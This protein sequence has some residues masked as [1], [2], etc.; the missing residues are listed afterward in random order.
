MLNWDSDKCILYAY[1]NKI[2]IP[3]VH[4]ETRTDVYDSFNEYMHSGIYDDVRNFLIPRFNDIMENSGSISIDPGSIHIQQLGISNYFN[5]TSYMVKVSFTRPKFGPSRLTTIVRI[6]NVTKEGYVEIDGVKYSYSYML[7]QQPVISYEV[8]KD[9]L[10]KIRNGENYINVINNKKSMK[11]QFSDIRNSGSKN[12]SLTSYSIL[13]VLF[14]MAINEGYDTRSV[15]SEFTDFSIVNAYTDETT[16]DQ[17]LFGIPGNEK[18]FAAT[19]YS[20]KIVPKLTLTELTS[21]YNSRSYNNSSIRNQLN[22]ML[23]LDRVKDEV[24]ARDVY[25]VKNPGKKLASSGSVITQSM[26]TSFKSEY[27]YKVYIKKFNNMDGLFLDEDID[28]TFAPKGL[29]ITEEIAKFFPDEKG[30]Y[31]SRD[32]TGS[33]IMSFKAGTVLN[34][35]VMNVLASVGY[36]AI[37][38]RSSNSSSGNSKQLYLMEECISNRQFLDIDV[39]KG[40]DGKWY[41]LNANNE[42]V[43]NNGA[44][45]TYDIAALISIATKIFAGNYRNIIVNADTGFRKRVVNIGEQYHNAF[46]YAV[47]AGFTQIKN[48]LRGF[49]KSSSSNKF[50]EDPDKIENNFYPITKSFVEYLRDIVRCLDRIDGD[51]VVNPI[52]F[53]SAVTRVNIY[54][55]DSHSVADSQRTLSIGSYGKLDPFEVP[56][57]GKLGVVNRLCCSTKIDKNGDLRTKYYP[58]RYASGTAKVLLNRER[59]MTAEEEE[60]YKIADISSIEVNEDGTIR[61]D[62]NTLIQCRV[63]S[64]DSI[65][66]STFAYVPVHDVDYVNADAQQTI[67]WACSTIPFMASNDSPRVTFAVAQEKQAKG[68]CEAEEPDVMT[69]SWEQFSW[70]NNK[71]CVRARKSGV[72]DSLVVQHNNGDIMSMGVIYDDGTNDMFD[73]PQIIDGPN[74]VTKLNPERREGERFDAGDI[75]ISSN[76][77]SENGIMTLGRNALVGY[78]CD[79]WNYEDGVHMSE[80]F[81]DKLRSYRLN[82]EKIEFNENT[83][84]KCRLSYPLSSGYLTPK[85]AKATVTYMRDR[86]RLTQ[87]VQCNNIY[88][89]YNDCSPIKSKIGRHSIYGIELSSLSVDRLE[90]GD[91]ISNR[92]GNKGVT[93]RISRTSEMPRLMNGKAL[94][95]CF[96]PLGVGS[97]MNI[98]QIK[99]LHTGLAAH[100]CK[101]RVST[102]AYNAISDEDINDLLSL[103]VDLMDSTGDASSVFSN[104]GRLFSEMD[105]ADE[106]KKY[107]LSNIDSIREYAGCFDKNGTTRLILPDN[108]GKLTETRIAVG[109]IYV[110]KLTQEVHKKIAAR[111]G[112]NDHES[113]SSV[114]GAPIQ[115]A[116]RGGGQKIGTMEVDALAA[117]GVYDYINELYNVRGDNAIDRSNF[118]N[119]T[120]LPESVHKKYHICK[121]GQRRSITEFLYYMLALGVMPECDNNEFVNLSKT[122]GDDLKHWSAHA[123]ISAESFKKEKMKASNVLKKKKQDSASIDSTVDSTSR[124]DI[125][126]VTMEDIDRK[127]LHSEDVDSD[128]SVVKRLNELT[129]ELVD[130]VNS[131]IDKESVKSMSDT[132]IMS[133][134][135]KK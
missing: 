7:E 15:Y 78:I 52:A 41:Y 33:I 91:K 48:S 113:Y 16:R 97:R 127:R 77:I 108:D 120:F 93:T 134:I 69:T 2:A 135:L 44:Y 3:K 22:E 96:N 98:G 115:G 74:S 24:L 43:E 47:N 75:I 130:S 114:G 102:D 58:I 17:H 133:K 117:Y 37:S 23:S 39:N 1:K 122:N 85:T 46:K 107:L 105:N 27:V 20:E 121:Q 89:F 28:V 100:V 81:S 71:F 112:L 30:M 125:S 95:I 73:V 79:G 51:N 53:E 62:T 123:L 80:A 92:H 38:V 8:S 10:I 11:I 88:G 57:S 87:K 55:K 66:K 67:S 68:I 21:I 59:W 101:Y 70:L 35:D 116:S 126:K 6:P 111:G 63:P 119:E 13:D 54:T 86:T 18:T 94:D 19:D 4:P 31:L 61:T 5:D 104:Y 36:S 82:K 56:Q 64:G 40:N 76:F 110:Y 29:K 129:D 72:V 50:F 103:T 90:I 109:F 128:N 65:E 99:E 42:L 49:G 60:K 25:S 26:L 106:F 14:A 9:Q 83:D 34:Y 124:S 84:Y 12:A 132:D 32:Y 118:I 131:K 45:T